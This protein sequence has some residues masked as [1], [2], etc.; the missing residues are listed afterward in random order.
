MLKRLLP[1]PADF[2]YRGSRLALWLLGL[3]LVLKL[4]VAL[5][6]IFNGRYAASVADGIPL[7]AYT[8][9]AAQTVLALFGTLGVT[10]ILL[11]ALGALV[12]FRYRALVPVFVLL[13]LIEY[14]ARKAV[15]LGMP[16]VRSG[17]S[18]GGAVNWAV[19]GVTLVAFILSL[20]PGRSSG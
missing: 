8:P 12:L 16:I 18:A 3:I 13:L 14:L 6:G 1:S 10:Q 20:Q 17:D 15:T 11:C 9:Q 4:G 19:L 5:G 2:T 7:D